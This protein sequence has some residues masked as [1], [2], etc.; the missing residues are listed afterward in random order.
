MDIVKHVR[1]FV[2]GADLN[3]ILAP[4]EYPLIK[5]STTTKGAFAG[6]IVRASRMLMSG[7][8]CSGDRVRL[9]QPELLQHAN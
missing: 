4:Y 9:P 8:E 6:S 3:S 1:I 2:E 7:A 5:G